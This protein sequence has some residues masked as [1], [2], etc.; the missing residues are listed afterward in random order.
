MRYRAVVQH[1]GSWEMGEGWV[2]RSRGLPE[3]SIAIATG[4]TLKLSTG[5]SQP[6]HLKTSRFLRANFAHPSSK[7]SLSVGAAH[8]VFE[9]GTAA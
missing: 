1:F 6:K 2:Y 3:Y 5:L 7:S 9:G 8:P 4:Y